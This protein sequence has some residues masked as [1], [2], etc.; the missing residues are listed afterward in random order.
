MIRNLEWK[1]LRRQQEAV[2]SGLKANPL[3][4][5]AFAAVGLSMQPP[6]VPQRPEGQPGKLGPGKRAALTLLGAVSWK[7]VGLGREA[8]HDKIA[9]NRAHWELSEQVKCPLLHSTFE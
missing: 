5:L 3:K 6:A 8:Y 7:D 2:A 4:M 9:T 1:D